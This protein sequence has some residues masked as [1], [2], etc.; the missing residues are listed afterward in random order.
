MATIGIDAR[1]IR[2][3]TGRYA[4]ELLAEIEKSDS[5]HEF[6]V[7][8]HHDDRGAW[9]TTD[10]RFRILEVPYDWYSFGEQWGFARY[11]RKLKLDLVHFTMPQ[12]PMRYIGRRVTTVQ[13]LTLVRFKNLDKSRLVYGIEQAVFR[14]LLKNVTRRSAMVI[15]PSRFTHDDIVRFA[16]L[17]PTKVRSIHDAAFFV[18]EASSDP[19]E[20]L[21]GSSFLFYVGNAFP[22]KNLPALVDAH[23]ALI[24]KHP[25]LY[26]VI[27]GKRDFFHD[28]LVLYATGSAQFIHLGFVSDAQLIWLY[29]HAQAVVFPSLSEGFGLPGLEAMAYGTPLVSSNATCLPEVYGNAAHFFDPNDVADMV[30][31]IGEVLTDEQLRADLVARGQVQVAKYSWEETA[32]QTLDVYE[33]ALGRSR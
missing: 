9:T 30:R 8:L 2:S 13:D 7:I 12:Q 33:E 28:E 18:P 20:S 26:L 24:E 19:I 29:S 15:T 23:R 3:T 4:R 10:A 6:V 25:D 5:E 31:A 17:D 21:V 1:R 32:R 11:L 22:H 16:D 14:F 27:A